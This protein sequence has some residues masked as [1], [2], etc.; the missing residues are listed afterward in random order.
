[1]NERGGPCLLETIGEEL[2][3]ILDVLLLL[4]ASFVD[5]IHID[6]A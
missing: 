5:G 6:D 2:D 3:V 1:M 4:R